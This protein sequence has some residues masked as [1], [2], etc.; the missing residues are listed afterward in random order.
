MA[1][2]SYTNWAGLSPANISVRPPA[3][4]CPNYPKVH[5]RAVVRA[6]R[7][8]WTK[9]VHVFDPLVDRIKIYT[10]PAGRRRPCAEWGIPEDQRLAGA[11]NDH[12]DRRVEGASPSVVRRRIEHVVEIGDPMP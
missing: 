7:A 11:D 6:A 2:P 12:A 10:V 9:F 5:H 3:R 1:M 4:N 8:A